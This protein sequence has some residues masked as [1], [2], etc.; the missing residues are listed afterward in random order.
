MEKH[1][2]SQ[3]EVKISSYEQDIACALKL[4]DMIMRIRH[5]RM[6]SKLRYYNMVLNE[7]ISAPRLE[8]EKPIRLTELVP[9]RGAEESTLKGRIRRRLERAKEALRL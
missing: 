5:Q 8:K 4:A 1:P 3:N 6:L 2:S 9:S 7:I